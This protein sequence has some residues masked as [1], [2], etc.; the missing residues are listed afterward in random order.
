[1]YRRQIGSLI[2]MVILLAWVSV[3]L[4]ETVSEEARRYMARGLAAVEMA[5][6]PKDYERAV[7]E[8]EQ[9]A[10]L[11]PNWPDVYFNLGSVQAKAGN[12]GEA[13]RH[14]KRYLELAPNAP[15]AT[16]V[17]EEIYKLEYRA[18]VQKVKEIKRDG[19]F[20]AYDNDT[21]LD[22]Q[23]NLMWAAKD[24]GA[25][26]NW[27]DA[28]KYCENYRGGGYTD[29]RMPTR[30]ELAGLYDAAKTYKSECPGLFGERGADV[31]LTGLISLTCNAPWA[32]ET[33]GSS[34]GAFEFTG[35]GRGMAPRSRATNNRALPVRSVPS[36]PTGAYK[37][38][39]NYENGD[40]YEG[41]FFNGKLHGKGIYTYANGDKYV[42]E[43]VDGKFTGRGTFTC[44]N[45]K[46]FTGNL[47][48]KVPLE[49]TIRCN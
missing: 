32:S 44:S 14:Y 24:N 22:T 21:V 39:R 10:K 6:T 19:R 37:G 16:K 41:E 30:D 23:T 12:Y 2:G 17:R 46:Q 9:A 38:V 8:F 4:A 31:H 48:N 27:Q 29:W 18:E 45:G 49:F 28:K 25:G 47:E 3:T 1:M 33:Y 15:D 40:K 13:M 36:P 11:A 7:R 26:I 20:I 42:G 34:G 5:K 35:G 43:F